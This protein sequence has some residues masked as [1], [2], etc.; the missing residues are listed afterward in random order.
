VLRS[1]PGFSGEG[2]WM[3]AALL[4]DAGVDTVVFG[5]AGQGAHAAEEWVDLA[6][7]E[8]VAQVLAEAAIQYCGRAW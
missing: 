1:E 2:P 3:D 7:L 8:C 4:A 5:P 6:S